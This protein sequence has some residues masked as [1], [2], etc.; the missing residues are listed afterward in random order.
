M[1]EVDMMRPGGTVADQDRTF[2]GTG[3]EAP[4]ITVLGVVEGEILETLESHGPMPLYRLI[5]AQERPASLVIM[6]VGALIRQGLLIGNE[7][8]LEAVAD[9][10]RRRA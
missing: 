7:H 8:R 10:R 5:Q 1:S 9:A 4:I 3:W 6:A 2:T